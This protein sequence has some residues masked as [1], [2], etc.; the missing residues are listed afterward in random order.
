MLIKYRSLFILIRIR[1]GRVRLVI[2][3]PLFVIT[4][5]LNAL[6]DWIW[7]WETIW[8]RSIRR[9]TKKPI[10]CNS[11]LV[12]PGFDKPITTG[13]K[14]IRQ[15]FQE[16]RRYGHWRMVEVVAKNPHTHE[17]THVYIDFI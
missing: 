12:K 16:L 3:L 11:R 8:P 2:P 5:A 1:A 15:F 10:W 4:Q 7:L 13:L 17:N 14:L 9:L 6:N